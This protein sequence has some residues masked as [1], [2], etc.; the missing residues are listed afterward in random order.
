MVKF[1]IERPVGVF[2]AA[3]L[4]GMAGF[5]AMSKLPVSLMPEIEIPQVTILVEGEAYASAE[6]EQVVLEPLRQKLLQTRYLA[7]IQSVAQ[8]GKGI[9]YLTFEFGQSMD[10]AFLDV[11]EKVD[12]TMSLLPPDIPRPR[13]VKSS[14]DDLP[15]VLVNVWKKDSEGVGKEESMLELS[16]FAEEVIK[17]RLEQSPSI[18]FIDINGSLYPEIQIIPDISKIRNLNLEWGVIEQAILKSQRYVGNVTVE[19]NRSRFNL[20]I[21]NKLGGIEEIEN[22]PL[23]FGESTIRLGEIA[24]VSYRKKV[25]Q[26]YNIFRSNEAISMAVIK[27]ADARVDDLKDALRSQLNILTRDNPELA[28]E[29]SQNQT[30]LLDFAIDNLVQ[31]L[32]IGS[33]LAFISIFLFLNDRKA[34]LLIF[35]SIPYA[36]LLSF[37]FLYVLDISLNILSLS[38]LVVSVGLMIDN[39]I[40]VIDNIQQY[41][42]RKLPPKEAAEQAV[43]EVVRP[44]LSSALTTCSVF[45]PLIFLGGLAGVLFFEQAVTISVGIGVSLLVAIFLIPVLY[46]QLSR[47]DTSSR[48]GSRFSRAVEERYERGLTLT[49]RRS[50][51][52]LLCVGMIGGLGIWATQELKVERLPQIEPLDTELMVSWKSTISL[53]ENR[54]RCEQLLQEVASAQVQSHAEVGRQQFKL[55]QGLP[56]KSNEAKMYFKAPSLEAL[57]EVKQRLEAFLTHTYPQARFSFRSGKNLFEQVLGEET[58]DVEVRM[59]SIAEGAVPP[60]A[61]ATTYTQYLSH[62]LKEQVVEPAKIKFQILRPDFDKMSLYGVGI[63][64]LIN[65]LTLSLSSLQVGKLVEGQIEIPIVLSQG[66]VEEDLNRTLRSCF[67]RSEKGK[68]VP[69]FELIRVERKSEYL[70]N[71]SDA[72]GAYVPFYLSV[73]EEKERWIV[74]ASE[75]FEA[76]NPELE[77]D[78]LSK[79]ADNRKLQRQ[80]LGIILLAIL[81]LYAILAAQFESL[82]LPFIVLAEIPLGVASSLLGLWLGGA[83]LNLMSLIGILVMIGIVINDSILKIDTINRHVKQGLPVNEAV[84]EAGRQR[85]NAI[86]MTSLTTIL[87]VVPFLFLSGIGA[88]LQQPLALA[89]IAGM[90]SGTLIS[91]FFIPLVYTFVKEKSARL[92]I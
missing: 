6:L 22:I 58:Y 64:P 16:R 37:L 65:Q 48:N 29:L 11:N 77:I 49:M 1:L 69:V 4:L 55:T 12:E 87:A 70:Y 46:V 23:T 47:K 76:E 42:Q 38:G 54:R 24:Q 72:R 14:P 80:L 43:L 66:R 83:T 89:L 10:Y 35:I 88:T 32:I 40:I 59:R 27:K 68:Y 5:L 81:V 9:I 75:R 91:L 71:L 60:A 86:L 92:S 78:I 74:D 2:V 13:V 21:G 53:E 30:D 41:Y 31:S 85:L 19:K 61:Q 44:L 79:S 52:I 34:P 90:I 20:R 67:V 17:R 56:A 73:G 39:S 3:I 82:L 25:A 84:R 63:D 8:E 18:A 57:N 36:I 45:L 15:I 62:I 51:V 7:D 26:G 28:F 50:W 33:I